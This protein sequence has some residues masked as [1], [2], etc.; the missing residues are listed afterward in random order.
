M[1]FRIVRP[2]TAFANDTRTGKVKKPRVKAAEHLKWI[3]TLPCLVTGQRPVDAAH[4]RY[5]DPD[6]GK[7]YTG[8][9][10]KP[11]D[12]WVVPLCRYEH[13]MQHRMSEYDYWRIKGINP[14]QVASALWANSGDDEAG[15]LIIKRARS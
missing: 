5:A 14:V 11:A 7:G 4:I 2:G 13:D 6:Y 8:K 3:R 10:E 9:G 1:S 15:L 12:K